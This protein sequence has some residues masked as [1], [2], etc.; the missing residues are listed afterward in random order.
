MPTVAELLKAAGVAD[1][2]AAGLPKE[3]VTALTGYVSEADTK[4][5]TATAEATKAEEARRQAELE[6]QEINEYVEKYGTTVTQVADAN[7]RAEAAETY[8]KSLKSQGFD[9]KYPGIE[10][11]E[12]EKKPI[13]PGSP[14]RG[15]N[16][17]SE[18]E[19]LGKVGVVM[20]Q[21]F[22][23]NNEH[24]RLYGSPIPDASMAVAEEADRARVPLG[25]YIEQKY[26]FAEARQ[27]KQDEAFQAKVDAEV[28]KKVEAERRA[29][30]ERRGNNPN[31]RG[32]ES[33]RS[34][35]LPKIKPDDFHKA[36]GNQTRRERMGRMLENIQ[37]DVETS[38]NNVA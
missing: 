9:I 18:K 17:V 15:G 29:E 16:V 5:Q 13:V 27:K 36:D 2:V 22:D 34:P 3:V 23:A 12:P 37:R 24:V 30:A 32:G 25:R 26:K 35:S 20:S 10:G 31:L 33:S 4:L 7:A 38:R 11:G 28:T 19:I 21:W 8:L 1:E 6:R 14:A